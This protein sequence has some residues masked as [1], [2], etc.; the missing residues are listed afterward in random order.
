MGK[1]FLTPDTESEATEGEPEAAGGKQKPQKTAVKKETGRGVAAPIAGGAKGES[2]V[3][4][5]PQQG[6]DTTPEE[7]AS[8]M[9]QFGIKKERGVSSSSTTAPAAAPGKAAA[10]PQT[11]AGRLPVSACTVRDIRPQY[12]PGA[13]VSVQ[14]GLKLRLQH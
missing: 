4:E 6:A 1:D 11:V 3:S 9:G 10:P 7:L 5:R 12:L 8:K 14:S 2:V 13:R